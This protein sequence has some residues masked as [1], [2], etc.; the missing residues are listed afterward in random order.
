M[1]TKLLFLFAFLAMLSLT[2]MAQLNGKKFT[3]DFEGMGKLFLEFEANTYKL[4]NA[5]EFEL[6]KGTYKIDDNKIIFNDVEGAISCPPDV[7]GEYEFIYGG[8]ELKLKLVN[9]EC[10]GRGAIAASVWK[11]VE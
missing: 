4:S 5:E 2:S 9:D 7:G 10:P 6:V 3:V 8:K 1:K 11:E